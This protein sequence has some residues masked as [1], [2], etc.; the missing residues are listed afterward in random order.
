MGSLWRLLTGSCRFL[1]VAPRLLPPPGPP[2]YPLAARA[3]LQV[4]RGPQGP[5]KWGKNRQDYPRECEEGINRQINQELTAFYV[6]LSMSYYFDREDV[7]LRNFAKFYF[8][9]AL[10][11]Q[12][13]AKLLMDFQNQRGGR[14]IFWDIKKPSRDEWGN[15]LEAMEQALELEKTVN[16]SILELHK[17]A[18]E[19]N[20]LVLCEFLESNYL[21][22]QIEA[23]RM[24]GDHITNLKRLGAPE[25]GMGEYLFDKHTLGEGS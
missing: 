4:R 23:I 25:N 13:H 16:K 22:E 6:Y 20:D 10:E 12:K 19:H 11:E 1:L 7:A 9:Q 18:S 24:F 2:C 8:E 15:G 21:N 3:Q 14:I 17:V 5:R